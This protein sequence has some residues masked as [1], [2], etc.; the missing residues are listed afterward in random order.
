M[1]YS[2]KTNGTK[3]R[4]AIVDIFRFIF[5]VIIMT[6]HSVV[7]GMKGDFP[8]S[9][10]GTFVEF[11]Y[12]LTGFYTCRHF[13][14]IGEIQSNKWILNGLKYTVKKYFL[15]FP[16]L[17]I[18]VGI[19][20]LYDGYKT[21][22]AGG[23]IEALKFLVNGI[24]EVFLLNYLFD[25]IRQVVGPLYYLS[26]MIIVLPLICILCQ[27]HNLTIRLSIAIYMV[28]FYYH[29]TEWA[30]TSQYPQVL[31]R[32]FSGMC[33]G[34]IAY[35][36]VN[37]INK[38]KIKWNKIIFIIGMVSLI[39]TIVFSYYGYNNRRNHLVL[40]FLGTVII[41]SNVNPWICSGN[42]ITD[43]LGKLSGV[44]YIFHFTVGIIIHGTFE[45]GF[46]MAQRLL[47]YYGVTISAA[48]VCLL[49][50]ERNKG[51]SI[52]RRKWKE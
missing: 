28:V 41:L 52:I 46:T 38:L 31:L 17:L 30:I 20:Y 8:F 49:V 18:S 27:C 47:M 29:N 2:L 15:L 33:M 6:S 43:F 7:F 3:G 14:N 50:V 39:M 9:V 4:N 22:V 5:C 10:V 37:H 40:V 23:G 16:Y 21:Y 48:I 32:A 51:R 24:F 45:V 42:I 25:D 13:E 11:F 36:I 35:S 26:A 34:I 19:A 12:I 1:I 44:I